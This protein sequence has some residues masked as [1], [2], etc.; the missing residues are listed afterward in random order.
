MIFDEYLSISREI[1]DQ[2]VL[3]FSNKERT[4]QFSFCTW[5][6]IDDETS[7]IDFLMITPTLNKLPDLLSEKNVLNL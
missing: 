5:L 2:K 1:N 4:T 3:K 6:K 7:P